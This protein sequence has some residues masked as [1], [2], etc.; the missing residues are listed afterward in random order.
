MSI[1]ITFG[2]F[3]C[4]PF[5]IEIEDLNHS[6]DDEV[7]YIVLGKTATYEIV[8]VRGLSYFTFGGCIAFI[9]TEIPSSA[10]RKSLRASYDEVFV[11]RYERR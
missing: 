8:F 3:S 11:G 5:A 2:W 4:D 10:T 9:R 7:I 6:T 1:S